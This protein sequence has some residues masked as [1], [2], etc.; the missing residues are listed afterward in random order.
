ML[1]LKA[2][3]PWSVLSPSNDDERDDHDRGQLG[4]QGQRHALERAVEAGGER[5][6]GQRAEH[7]ERCCGW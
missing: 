4:R 3:K 2:P 1:Q 5:R 7:G 6:H